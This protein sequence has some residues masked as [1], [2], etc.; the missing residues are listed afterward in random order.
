MLHFRPARGPTIATAIM[1]PVLIGL[2]V[3]QVER[4][5]WKEGLIAAIDRNIHT[6]PV[7]LDAGR[8][9][10]QKNDEY[11]HVA[12]RG[13]FDNSKETYLFASDLAGDPGYHVVTPLVTD[14]GRTYLVDRGYVPPERRDPATR[15]EGQVGGEQQVAGYWRWPT[16]PGLFTPKPDLAHRIW[17]SRDAAAMA[18]AVHVSPAQ[19]AIVDADAKPNPGGWPR[20]GQ[21]IVDIPNNHLSYA[22][23]WFGLAVVLTGVYFAFHVSQGRLKLNG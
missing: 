16:A 14:D 23:T 21:T 19:D 10:P 20:G 9:Q 17:F 11:L 6:P 18:K 5:H 15:P 22:F 7:M 1:L 12:V 4:L 8:M 2:G 13:R 3:W